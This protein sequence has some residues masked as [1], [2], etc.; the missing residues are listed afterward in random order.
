MWTHLMFSLFL[1]L[2]RNVHSLICYTTDFEKVLEGNVT[3]LSNKLQ[4]CAGYNDK[5]RQI[6]PEL[7]IPTDFTLHSIH[8]YTFEVGRDVVIKGCVRSGGCDV[9]MDVLKN[10]VQKIQT[11][12]A[13]KVE[14]TECNHDKCNIGYDIIEPTAPASLTAPRGE[15]SLKCYHC[16]EPCEIAKSRERIC[17]GNIGKSYEA[18]CTTEIPESIETS[19]LAIRKCQIVQKGQEPS[20]SLNSICTSC[21]SDLCNTI[22][23]SDV[24]D[25]TS[26]TTRATTIITLWVWLTTFLFL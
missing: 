2:F 18:V 14:C 17:G 9:I 7:Q 21:K 10:T 25:V 24:S 6:D 15:T 16:A 3:R 20:C 19:N 11:F 1:C 13:G 26:A 23:I 22:V 4:D 5:V 8:C 12:D